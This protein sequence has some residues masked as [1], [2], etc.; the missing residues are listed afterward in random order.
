[1]FYQQALTLCTVAVEADD[2]NQREKA[3]A[4]YAA[5]SD[6]FVAGYRLDDNQSRRA[7]ILSRVHSFVGRA[8]TLKTSLRT[9]SAPTPTT[10]ATNSRKRPRAS[11]TTTTSSTTTTTFHDVIGLRQAK[12]SLIESIILPQKQPQLFTG[13]R[14]PFNGILLYGPPGT[15]KTLL[16][17]AVANES[18]TTTTFITISASDIMS[19][20]QGESER[21]LKDI[22][23]RARQSSPCI[24]F[25]DEVDSLGRVRQANEKAATRRIKTELLMQM[26]GLGKGNNAGVVVIGATNTPWELDPALRRRFQKR[27]MTP[28]PNA[29]ERNQ[30]LQVY[31]DGETDLSPHDFDRIS[32]ATAHYSAS[33]ISIL[34]REALMVPV[35]HCLRATH[36]KQLR[37]GSVVP[38]SDNDQQGRRL[39]IWSEDFDPRRL[40]APKVTTRD[41]QEALNNSKSSVGVDDLEKCLLF[42]REFGE[43][44]L[45]GSGR[46]P[47]GKVKGNSRSNSS[48]SSSSSSGGVVNFFKG[49]FGFGNVSELPVAPTA[50]VETEA[51][52]GERKAGER[53]AVAM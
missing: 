52:V 3:I 31:L 19:K 30:L 35:R 39:N 4:H 13:S 7:V 21:A 26:D 1:M 50:M 37:N 14:K 23:D 17:Q 34:A 38:C 11:T 16:A 41:M 43:G 47:V 24:I 40:A 22:F 5:A 2:N 36:F 48:S 45:Q 51:S 25:I 33:D 32:Q 15:G 9:R 46:H 8:E 44:V 49:L 27:I 20:Y 18:D 6:Y 53:T 42:N 29:A 10:A 28:L 12:Q